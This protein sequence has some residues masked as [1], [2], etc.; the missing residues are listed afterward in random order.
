MTDSP[1]PAARLRAL[2]GLRGVAAVGVVISHLVVATN[3]ALASQFFE[4]PQALT[5]F[6]W[7]IAE[8]PLS[9]FWAGQEWVFVFFVL[10]G[11]VLSLAAAGGAR[12]DAARYY[13]TRVVRLYLPVWAMLVLAALLHEVVAHE[14]VAGATP[15][16]NLHATGFS[17][18]TTLHELVLLVDPGDYYYSTVL[19]TQQWEVGFSIALPLF[20]LCARRFPLLLLGTASL[21]VITLGGAELGL[22]R[23]VP[24]FTLGTVLAFGR[25]HVV[26]ALADNRLYAVTLAASPVLLTAANWM[27][28]GPWEGLDFGMAA[29]GASGLVATAMVPGPFGR[30]LQTR[31]LQAVGIRSYSLYLVH[32]PIIVTTA[33]ALGGRPSTLV[34]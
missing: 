34:L 15:W 25:E 1:R 20:I 18:T 14:P 2:D 32:E 10:S 23:Y 31:P 9:I 11:F 28:E 29:L 7:L 26:R 8:T 5:G 4:A 27:P 22:L 3:V 16:L 6:A 33:F 12:F 30:W 19:W 24:M 21:L 17:A 13:P